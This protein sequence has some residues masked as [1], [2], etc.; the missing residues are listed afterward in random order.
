MK[1]IRGGFEFWI[2][3]EFATYLAHA[4]VI[5]IHENFFRL[6]AQKS[7]PSLTLAVKLLEY[8]C[9]N[10]G[11]VQSNTLSVKSL[12]KAMPTIPSYESLTVNKLVVR[13]D[14]NEMVHKKIGDKGGWRNRIKKPFDMA[15]NTLADSGILKEWYYRESPEVRSYEDFIQ[16]S[17]CFEFNFQT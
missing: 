11:N 4:G 9:M 13:D 16:Q 6:D 1:P 10:K 17:I 12:L 7:A 3:K 15:F 5:A 2:N 14:G 8:H